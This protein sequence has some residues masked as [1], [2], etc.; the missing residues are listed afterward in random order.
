MNIN[1]DDGFSF[2]PPMSP[3]SP[4]SDDS[5]EKN[6]DAYIGSLSDEH[7]AAA[8]YAVIISGLPG[9]TSGEENIEGKLTQVEALTFTLATVANWPYERA[10]KALI[11]ALVNILNLL[12]KDKSTTSPSDSF[13]SN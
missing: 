2:F 5:E 12:P 8:L 11:K 4:S 6:V 9:I 13:G 1:K 10:R 3:K 7:R